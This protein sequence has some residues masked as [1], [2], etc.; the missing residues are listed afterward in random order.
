MNSN[1]ELMRRNL[2]GLMY[3]DDV[4]LFAKSIYQGFEIMYVQSLM[5]MV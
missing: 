3:A 2:A 1:G 5:N 4:C